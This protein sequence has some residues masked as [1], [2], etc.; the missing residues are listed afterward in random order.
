MPLSIG[1]AYGLFLG[2]LPMLSGDYFLEAA[3]DNIVAKAGGGQTGAFQINTQTSRV[4]TVATA[5]DS[6]VLPASTAGLELLVINH[7]ANAMQVFG[8]SPDTID[9]QATATGVSQMAGSLV[10]YTSAASGAWYSEGLGTGFSTSLGLQTLQYAV[11]AANTTVT[12]AAGTPIKAI[13]NHVTSTAAGAITLPPSTP[14]L[15][16]S[17]ALATAA[18]AV[19]VFPNAGGTGTEQINALAANAGYAM[20]A[21][22]STTFICAVA[23]Q[24]FTVPR[25]AS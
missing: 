10:I 6:I 5:G 19:T 25:V 3:Q 1:R 20:T 21:L 7:G 15:E 16:I 8:T 13:V 24:W 9:D 14:G 11:V 23:G 18:N 2:N 4:T 12:Q 22:T 17:V